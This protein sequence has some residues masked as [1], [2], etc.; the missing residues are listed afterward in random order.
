MDDEMLPGSDTL[1]G[2]LREVEDE[3]YRAQQVALESGHVRCGECETETP[4]ADFTVDGYR[5]LEGT[6][7]A[8]ELM[9]L[10]WSACPACEARGALVLGYGPNAS[11]ADAT[12]LDGLQLPDDDDEGATP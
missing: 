12:V 5:R 3:G 2:A 8:A 1:V 4:A 10:T 11:A 7:D 6:S 9:L